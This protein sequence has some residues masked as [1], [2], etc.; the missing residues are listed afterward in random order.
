M[1]GMCWHI[2]LVSQCGKQS[3]MNTATTII[4]AV[5]T[6]LLTSDTFSAGLVNMANYFGNIILPICAG[7]VIALGIY[8]YSL[9]KDGQRFIVGGLACLLVSGFVREAEFFIGSTTG[10]TMFM[11]GI[12]GLVNWVCNVIL[13]LYAALCIS[14][15]ALVFGGFG[16]RLFIGDD[17]ARYFITGGA[18]LG[19]S[20]IVRL[21]EYF[22]VDSHGGLH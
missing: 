16:E 22:V 1:G 2:P 3:P 5:A 7:L 11:T 14:R 9:R 8:A 4:H 20:A 19:C 18:C 15:G 21:L 6:V 13:P 10:S 12:L 17:W